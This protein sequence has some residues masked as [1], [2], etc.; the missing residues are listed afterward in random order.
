MR[1]INTQ[2]FQKRW[3]TLFVKGKDGVNLQQSLFWAQF[4]CF[5]AEIIKKAFILIK[6]EWDQV[7]KFKKR[8]KKKSAKP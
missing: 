5:T 8:R 7:L 6:Q 4:W 2:S 3:D 1:E